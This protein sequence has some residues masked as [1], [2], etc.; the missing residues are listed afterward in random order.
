[1]AH[2]TFCQEKVGRLKIKTEIPFFCSPRERITIAYWHALQCTPRSFL[3]VILLFYSKK[4]CATWTIFFRMK[5]IRNSGNTWYKTGMEEVYNI[6][7]R[8]RIDMIP[9][10][11]TTMFAEAHWS[12]LKR[13]V[14]LKHNRPRIDLV[15]FLLDT[16]VIPGIKMDMDLLLKGTTKP[17]WYTAFS[18]IWRKAKDAT[19][20][21]VYF[22]DK[23][24]WTCSCMAFLRSPFNICKNLICDS[25]V[26]PYR[27]LYWR[28]SPPFLIIKRVHTRFTA[29]LDD[30]IPG[31]AHVQGVPLLSS[32]PLRTEDVGDTL[33]SAVPYSLAAIVHAEDTN[34]QDSS[35]VLKS[36]LNELDWVRD[37]ARDLANTSAGTRQ[38]RHL[39]SVHIS[40][41][42]EYRK[43]IEANSAGVACPVH[44]RT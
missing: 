19:S 37:H 40:K 23:E 26:P 30:E 44:S 13:G 21:H 11:R 32:V 31:N 6:W 34:A 5:L 43:K 12:M 4:Q 14:L 9:M 33:R 42:V 38:L 27:D 8:Q 20:N 17:K 15:V 35:E 1:M 2:E 18:R 10:S 39:H 22:T 16:E 7:G 41:L 28:R 25:P 3:G 36:I 24:R 29:N